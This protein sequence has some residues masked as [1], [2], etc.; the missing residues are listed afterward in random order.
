[1]MQI[2]SGKAN[3][4]PVSAYFPPLSSQYVPPGHIPAPPYRFCVPANPVPEALRLHAEL[5]LFKI[6]H[7][8]N[9][10]GLERK[11]ES[12]AA[13]TDAVSGLPLIGAE[14][15]LVLPGLAKLAP[16]PYRSSVLVERGKHLVGLAQQ[17][18]A[19][20]LSTLEKADAERYSKLK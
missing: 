19:N 10:A 9:I 2:K 5:N 13:P 4:G 16:T 14:G 8:R 11:P 7:C 15:Q 3:A 1:A 17:I 12:Y 20:F 18:E 6:R